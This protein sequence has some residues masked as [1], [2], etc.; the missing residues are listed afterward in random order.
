MPTVQGAGKKE[1][2]VQELTDENKRLRDLVTAKAS[3][4]P[5]WCGYLYK[6]RPYAAGLLH[7]PWELRFVV[8]SGCVLQYYKSERDT[9]FHPRGHINLAGTV[10]EVEGVKNRRFWTFGV[11]DRSGLSL[12]RLSSESQEEADKWLLALERAGCERRELTPDARSR[13]PLRSADVRWEKRG[14][15]PVPGSAPKANTPGVRNRYR[16]EAQREQLEASSSDSK[17]E[18]SLMIASTPMHTAPRASLLSSER[19]AHQRHAGLINLGMV[20]L[21]AAN[22]RL[23]IENLLKYGIRFNLANY[24][25][26]ALQ[27]SGN[28]ALLLC[29]PGLLACCLTAYAIECLGLL[30]VKREIKAADALVKK[31]MPR[32]EARRTARGSSLLLRTDTWMAALNLCNLTVELVGPC[33]VVLCTPPDPLSSFFLVFTA[34]VWWLKLVSYA[35]TNWDLRNARRFDQVRPGERGSGQGLEGCG[36]APLQYPE[37]LT[38]ANLCYFVLVPTLCYQVNYPRNTRFRPRWLLRRLLELAIYMGLLLFITDQYI[39]PTIYN[40]LGPL[41]DMDWVRCVERLLKLALP[42]LYWWLVMF[43]LLFHVWLNILAEVTRF[44]DREFYK[45]WWNATTIG[46]YWR[47]WNQ[48]VHKWVLRHVYYPLNR[49]GVSKAAAGI[50]V[51]LI[52]A[53]FHELL[54]GVPLHMLRAWAFLGIMGQVPMMYLTEALRKK[55]KNDQVGNIIFWISFCII[56]QPLSLMLYYHEWAQ[57]HKPV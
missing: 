54:V 36:D 34:V 19:V 32:S 9:V 53:F 52:S 40:S 51:F 30:L 56:G 10:L 42:T 1:P 50:V 21:I 7:Q 22:S 49:H 47:T 25:R 5:S 44:A 11:A 45:D 8:V 17:A 2:T 55:V 28:L 35:H 31:G 48:P 29:W 27:P 46:E 18:R 23:I 33:A 4:A 26:S 12:I 37:N 13:S 3:H 39:G 43:Y 6:Y 20:I 14:S 38:L 41:Q 16:G 15:S 57:A 24:V